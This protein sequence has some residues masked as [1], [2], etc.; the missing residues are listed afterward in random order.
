V[1]HSPRRRPGFHPSPPRLASSLIVFILT[2]FCAV[3]PLPAEIPF[4]WTG[5][6]RVI[7]I[8]DLHGDY[9]N[10]EKIIK[11]KGIEL[12]DSALHW[13]GGKTHL[14]QTGDIM[15]R[16]DDARKILDV[17]MRLETEAEATGG[18]VHVLIGNH[19]ELNIGGLI[20]RYPDYVTW[21]EF[22]DFLPDE[23]RRTQERNLERRILRAEARNDRRSPEDIRI[24]FWNDLKNQPDGQRQYL[25]GFNDRYGAW[26]LRH[27]AVI[28]I[29]NTVFVHGGISEKYSLWGIEKINE[30][31]RLELAAYEL[32]RLL[33]VEI[34]PPVVE[35]KIEGRTG[36][37]Q[38]FLE[39]CVSE[40]DR[41]R[42]KLQPPDPRAFANALDGVRV[43]ESLV[44]DECSNYTD[45]LVLLEDWQ[46]CRV[47]FSEAFAPSEELRAGCEIT[48]CSRKLY[49]GLTKLA[50]VT[51]EAAM[52]AYL[53]DGEIK[54]LLIRKSLIVEKIKSLIAEKGEAAVLF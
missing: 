38:I 15:D 5:V 12:V 10:F 50:D 43:F 54:A 45:L 1:E 13:S 18:K 49:E 19:E 27:N 46:C 24:E 53:S 47:D 34:V 22:F 28:K 9:E 39:N 30:R 31:F 51:I 8:G 33:G 42:K 25:V 3:F 6:E 32:N 44:G 17:L 23:Y 16:G 26:L 40:Q 36:S 29:D 11:G 48:V 20:S 52:K 41:R 2:A 35:R 7:V 21:H 4:I 14:V 37:L